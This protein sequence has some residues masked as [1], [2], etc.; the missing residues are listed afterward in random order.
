MQISDAK[1]AE[2]HWR[3]LRLHYAKSPCFSQYG[4]YFA[5]LYS[6]CRAKYLTEINRI[7]IESICELL[8]INTRL[9]TCDDYPVD[10]HLD[11][12]ERLAALCLSAGGTEYVSGE[13]AKAYLHADVFA[14]LGIQLSYTDY[15]AYPEYPQ[16]FGPF[17]H[18]VSILDL[19][20]NTGERAVDFMRHAGK[21]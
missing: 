6:S 3:T 9:S 18:Q 1:W 8:G 13:S 15:S 19:I 16:L 2:R 21:S 14:D 20:F 12:S 10:E 4:D 7:F 5:G 17:V 11:R